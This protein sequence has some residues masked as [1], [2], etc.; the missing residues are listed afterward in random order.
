MK[1]YEKSSKNHQNSENILK[2]HKNYQFSV[3]NRKHP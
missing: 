3:K 1:I 2:F